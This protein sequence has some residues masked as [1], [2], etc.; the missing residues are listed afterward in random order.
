MNKDVIVLGAGGHAKVL[1]DAL[2]LSGIPI[3]GVTDPRR[4]DSS[5]QLLGIV[6]LGGDEVV[7]GFAT[8]EIE[9]V[10]AVGGT[11]DLLPRRRLFERFKS[12]GFA[13]VRVVHPLAIVSD[14]AFLEEGAQIL[15]G[16]V[17]QPC[18]IVEVNAVINTKASVDH[19]CRIGAHSHVAPG[20]TICGNVVVGI[21]TLI[22]AGAVIIQ[23]V[24]VGNNCTVGAGAV[25]IS[26][27][28]DNDTVCGIPARPIRR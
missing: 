19:D 27:V 4:C 10:N 5:S 9:L 3:M 24:R 22:G 14:E 7:E 6:N 8:S 16:A 25:V 15:A 13:F 1:I 20:A 2:R 28:N 17:V 11:R 23:N 12:R 18:A 26:D 21:Q